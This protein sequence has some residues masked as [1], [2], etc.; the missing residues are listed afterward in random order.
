MTD[1]STKTSCHVHY[2]ERKTR[3][4]TV[5]REERWRIIKNVMGEGNS[6]LL[7]KE[8]SCSKEQRGCLDRKHF[9]LS[10]FVAVFCSLKFVSSR[11]SLS[12]SVDQC[13]CDQPFSDLWYFRFSSLPFIMDAGTLLIWK[14]LGISVPT[15]LYCVYPL[16]SQ[17]RV[18]ETS[19]NFPSQK[20]RCLCSS[21]TVLF[22][23]LRLSG[24][25]DQC[26]DV[27]WRQDDR[28]GGG[29]RN[30]DASLQGTPK[31]TTS[32]RP[33]WTKLASVIRDGDEC[34]FVSDV[35]TRS[36][37]RRKNWATWTLFR[38]ESFSKKYTEASRN[39]RG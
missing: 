36:T 13:H 8:P 2:Q 1:L 10:S 16:L 32:F 11:S 9:A 30:C 37:W 24:S 7:K 20:S 25:D 19:L 31:G 15:R 4:S 3:K 22:C 28:G 5:R 18:G 26:A 12:R 17:S 35:N 34:Q 14:R 29:A 6:P 38:L 27:S 39:C 21:V 23:R 33:E